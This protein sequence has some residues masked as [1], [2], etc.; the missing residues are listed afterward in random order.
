MANGFLPYLL[1]TQK[2]VFGGA[3]P[4]QKITP[5]GFLAMLLGNT[6]PNIVSSTI[7]DGSGHV[8]DVKIKYRPRSIAGLSIT[9]DD[10]TVQS[11]PMYQE[12]TIPALS[13]RKHG[14][15]LDYDT[16]AKYEKEAS[17]TI[18]LG[19]PALPKGIVMEIYNSLI[20][21]ANGLLQDVNGDLLTAQAARFGKNVTT[22]LNTAKTVN[23]PLST[24]S[25]PLTQGLTMLTQD[26][27]QNE[28]KMGNFFLVGDGLINGVYVQQAYNTQNTKD[29]NYPALF[30]KYYW[31][32]MATSK[33]GANQFGVFEKNAVQ[34]I[35]VNKFNG[36][37]GGDKLSTF[38]TTIELP[39]ADSLGGTE[40]QS[41]KFD[42]QIRHIDCPQEIEI[43]GVTTM[44]PRGW[45]VDLMAN[46]GLFG[47]PSDAYL[48]GD[49]LTGNN[50]TLRY[51]ATNV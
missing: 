11:K 37:I 29:Q 1:L 48:A 46:Y 16:I 26:V 42:L 21:A 2:Q 14:I 15:F 40:L 45:V 39:L 4:S 41:F 18:A 32:P 38:L 20:E 34:L 12:Q 44:V 49:R 33:L 3:T 22:G 31:D 25:N 30:P 9:T 13:F 51:T 28:I 36:F 8:R 23:F 50:G 27:M 7:D 47:I 17:E 19:K 24:A 6:M 5:L 43:G 35:N 10:C